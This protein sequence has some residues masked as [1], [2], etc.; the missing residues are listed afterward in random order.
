MV[1]SSKGNNLGKSLSKSKN[2]TILAKPRELKNSSKLFKFKKTIL[3]KF[4]IMINLIVA[5]ILGFLTAKARVFFTY[6]REIFIKV[7]I[8]LEF[9]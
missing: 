5:N 1:S 8:F 4:K 6:L 7:L 9:D 3:D 2:A